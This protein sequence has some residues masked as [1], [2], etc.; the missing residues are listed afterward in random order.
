MRK[1]V[2]SFVM[3]L[4]AS[5]SL[6]ATDL[7]IYA[8]GLRATQSAGVTTIEYTLNAQATAVNLKLY[9][10]ASLE[11]TLP[12][13]GAS[14]LT[15]GSHS[16]TVD[17]SEVAVGTYTWKLEASAAANG[18]AAPAEI[19]SYPLSVANAYSYEFPQDVVVDNN[20]ESSYFGRIY[21]SEARDGKPAAMTASGTPTF[22]MYIYNPD[23]TFAN[24]STT[25][26]VGYN[27]GITKGDRTSFRRLAIDEAGKVYVCSTHSNTK[28]VYRMNP[29][30]PSANFEAVLSGKSVNAI[31]VSGNILSTLEDIAVG[32]GT[33]NTYD[34]TTVPAQTR[35]T[36]VNTGASDFIYFANEYC[37]VRNDKNGGRWLCEN[38]G[39]ADNYSYAVHLNSSNEQDFVIKNATEG[40]YGLEFSIR[41][42][43]AVSP[44]GGK[45]AIGST[46]KVVVYNVTYDA[47]TG[48]PTLSILYTITRASG[49]N[50]DGI[51]FDV[52]GN[53]YVVSAASERF[54]AYAFPKAVN[55]FETPAP[56]ANTI[57]WDGNVTHVTGV[58]LNQTSASIVKGG[59]LT[60]V[61]TITPN[62]ATNMNVSWSSNH[63][64]FATVSDE[65][66][67]TAVAPG[68]A[69]ITVTTDDGSFTATCEVT[70]TYTAVADVALNK[71]ETSLFAGYKET[72]TATVTPNDA[73]EPELAW[74]SLS[75]AVAT[76]SNAGVVTALTP[77]TAQIVVKSVSNEEKADT[78]VVTVAAY[79]MSLNTY[80]KEQTIAQLTGK[81]IRRIVPYERYLYVLALGAENEPFLYRINTLTDAVVSIPTDFCSKVDASGLKLS[82]IAVTSDGVLV[83]CNK[84]KCTFTPANSFKVY[85]W[86]ETDGAF[87]GSVWFSKA[88][89]KTC[90]NFTTAYTGESMVYVGSLANG[91]VVASARTTGSNG[92][93]R[94]NISNIT[95]SAVASTTYN[96][97]VSPLTSVAMGT[98]FKLNVLA[99]GVTFVLDGSL[100]KPY[101]FKFIASETTNISSSLLMPTADVKGISNYLKYDGRQLALTNHFAEA[102]NDGFVVNE[103]INDLDPAVNVSADAL[104]AK[105]AT[106]ASAVGEVWNNNAYVY[107][108]RDDELSVFTTAPVYSNLYLYDSQDGWGLNEGVAMEQVSVNVFRT[109]LTANND[110]ITFSNLQGSAAGD[111]DGIAAGRLSAVADGE[112]YWITKDVENASM[113]IGGGKCYY[114]S[115]EKAGKYEITVDLNTMKVQFVKLT[116]NLY[117][118]DNQNGWNL[119]SGLAMTKVANNI[120]EGEFT[121]YGGD[122]YIAFSTTQGSSAEDWSGISAG[123]IMITSDGDYWVTADETEVSF[124]AGNGTNSFKILAANGGTYRV[125]V[126][127]T[128]KKINVVRLS[129]IVTVAEAGYATYYNGVHAYVMPENMIGYPFVVATGLDEAAKYVKDDV[130]PA[131]TPL[132]LAAAQ[133]SYE[134]MFTTGGDAPADNDLLGTDVE[135]NLAVADA[136]ADDYYY[137]GLSL[138]SSSAV[139][140]VGF[141]W[142]NETG[143]AFVNGAHKAYLRVAKGGSGA[144]PH[145]YLFRGENNTTSLVNID[146]SDEAVKFFENGQMFIRRDGVVYDATGR[147][148][149]K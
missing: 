22:G 32:V 91:K 61:P 6:Y 115:A 109:E 26:M 33:C 41:G 131:G 106:F 121:L 24:G 38:R 67:V 105:A 14:N 148:V 89:T 110:Y 149:R 113:V 118:F 72:L 142:M 30:D 20:P 125:T 51:A 18:L 55:T 46:K 64:E 79:A 137:Y 47:L 43:V 23:L 10:G 139:N 59:T 123:R 128:T 117:G 54:Y 103:L 81:T 8:S 102:N 119:N 68:V 35:A 4:L 87:A 116:E 49:G 45:I 73:T 25:A 69:T 99:D 138:N 31:D 11:A 95:N 63:E 90:G 126:N 2:F 52:A 114:V 130:V 27:G 57:T 7:N 78:C 140:S 1:K 97:T 56:T 104:A 145:F 39:V 133:G 132:V 147:M 16:V 12:I 44:D 29:A 100:S 96:R 82:D 98:D 86:T 77:G 101:Y 60:L 66:V 143:A 62:N 107:A 9:D 13:T 127:Y 146:N 92:N 3:A 15:A 129:A 144:A 85:K 34:I 136:D 83:G 42:I 40:T 94:F 124:T 75:P 19:T 37:S 65:G 112:N 88:E 17:L 122:R 21:V 28:G 5:V 53:L 36:S 135:T 84:E 58:S 93:I 71:T 134:L 48:V 141:Y 76:V 120:F 111:W 80:F 108:L 70:V 74:E 50:T